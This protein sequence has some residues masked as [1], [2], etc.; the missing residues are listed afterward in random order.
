MKE[1]ETTSAHIYRDKSEVPWGIQTH[2]P[3]WFLSV[4]MFPFVLGSCLAMHTSP[5]MW[6]PWPWRT[7][8][9][10]TWQSFPKLL[11]LQLRGNRV[12]PEQ[13]P[14][15]HNPKQCFQPPMLANIFWHLQTQGYKSLY[16]REMSQRKTKKKLD[17]LLCCTVFYIFFPIVYKDI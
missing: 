12:C 1:I 14:L 6:R 11:Y 7:T 13:L 10:Y 9:L 8:T 15:E 2:I 16:S 17:N 3:L 5:C 4:L